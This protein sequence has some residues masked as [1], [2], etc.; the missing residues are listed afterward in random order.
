MVKISM[1]SDPDPSRTLLRVENARDGFG[2]RF[3]LL[4]LKANT[5]CVFMSHTPQAIEPI[6]S[7]IA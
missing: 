7:E 2:L 5:T 6:P 1:H 4:F 3:L